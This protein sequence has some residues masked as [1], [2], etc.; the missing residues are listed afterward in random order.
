MII[1]D[2]CA[3]FDENQASI[4]EVVLN[5]KMCPWYTVNCT[6]QTNKPLST[7]QQEGKGYNN[8]FEYS[9]IFCFGAHSPYV[10]MSQVMRFGC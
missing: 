10:N 8:R 4:V 1:V 6:T 9:T 5:N 7:C 2:T 3:N